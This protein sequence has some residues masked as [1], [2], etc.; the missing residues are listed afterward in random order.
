MR[1]D[2]GMADEIIHRGVEEIRQ[3]PQGLDIRLVRAIFIFVYRRL[4]AADSIRQ[5]LLADPFIFSQKPYA[6]QA[7]SPRIHYNKELC[8]LLIPYNYY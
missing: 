7:A 5:T 2:I 1:Y 8:S 4:C 6:F 3:K